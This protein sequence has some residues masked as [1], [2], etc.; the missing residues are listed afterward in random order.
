MLVPECTG[1]IYI[2]IL[3]PDIHFL[4]I[5]HLFG[6]PLF[7]VDPFV[8]CRASSLSA[9]VLVYFIVALFVFPDPERERRAGLT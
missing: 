6:F 7:P 5:I 3:G 4:L 9:E 8:V 2:Y 1:G